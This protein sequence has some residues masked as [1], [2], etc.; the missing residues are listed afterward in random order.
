ME[1]NERSED[2][3]LT[4]D[5]DAQ[6]NVVVNSP[7]SEEDTIDLGRVFHNMKI[8]ARVFA[9][10]L[11]LCLLVGVCAPLLLY[12]FQ[13]PMLTVSS[14]VT[15]KYEAPIMVTVKE[16]DSVTG[17]EI[18]SREPARDEDGNII[19]EPVHNLTAPDGEELDLNQ[20][21]S[22]YVMQQ[23]LSGM[24]LK[25][26]V[27][28][29]AL[30][31]NIV[32]ER[33]LTDEARQAQE[34]ASQM[35]TDKNSAAYDQLVN[36]KL[37]YN[38]TFVVRLSNGFGEEDSSSKIELDDG[39]LKL[40]LDRILIA[41]NDYLVMTYADLKLPADEVSI[42]D[43]DHL[44]LL[45]SLELLRTASDNLYDYCEKKSE[46][47]RG[48]RSY[49]DGRSLNDWMETIKTGKETAVDYL[50]SYVYNNSIVRDRES[51]ITNYQFQ[52]R[53]AQTQLDMV[54]DN[55]AATKEILDSYKNDQIYVSMQESDGSKTTKTTTDYYNKLV[56]Q[57][58]GYYEELAKLETTIV[59][60]NDKIA[61]L[62]NNTS[63]AKATAETI[64]D[65]ETD[66][67]KTLETCKDIYQGVRDHMTELMNTS[68]Y[69]QYAD[70]TVPQGKL[71]N[72][73]TAN[74]KKILIGAAAGIV[75]ACGLWF[76]AALA[77]EF[78]RNRKEE[79]DGKEAADHE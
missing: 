6:I 9:W 76:L 77:P 41:Y 4:I 59:D 38:P 7:D 22:S 73:I 62:Q 43:V 47:I 23:A 12:Q 40:L 60:L 74:L 66:L 79:K 2:K 54:N 61:S 52:L 45:E 20:I 10:V 42:I 25:E 48:Y 55:I 70:H 11:V 18:E 14:A 26:N 58:A 34:L 65:V 17:L 63:S 36:I 28:L 69:N 31:S 64:A 72:F 68:F 51:M 3:K 78:R 71:D 30:R 56:Q 50:Y 16:R 27:S 32:I 19:Y 75:I 37:D 35:M 49:K 5:R 44:D 53:N 21:T 8:K 29:A 39:E 15:L 13:K 46:T 67:K 24:D 1:S 57:I 33:V